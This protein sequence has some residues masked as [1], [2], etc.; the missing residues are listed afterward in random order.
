MYPLF[1][2]CSV[3]VRVAQNDTLRDAHKMYFIHFGAD[4]MSHRGV[5]VGYHKSFIV[6]FATAHFALHLFIFFYNIKE[7]K[8]IFCFDIKRQE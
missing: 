3:I 7:N 4:T 5:Q 1:A 6:Y 8:K 2:H